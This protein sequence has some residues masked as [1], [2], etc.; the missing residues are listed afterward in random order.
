M[1]DQLDTTTRGEQPGEG[2]QFAAITSQIILDEK[3]KGKQI[4]LVDSTGELIP[5]V[6]SGIMLVEGELVA[7]FHFDSNGYDIDVPLR[8]GESIL[9]RDTASKTDY[10]YSEPII[11]F[12]TYVVLIITPPRPISHL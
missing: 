5:L 11:V 6:F 3:S 10:A 4:P 8:T 9:L 7:Q 1:T 12:P 2:H